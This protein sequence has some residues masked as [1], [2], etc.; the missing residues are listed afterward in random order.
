MKAW[1]DGLKPK[2]KPPAVPG[3]TPYWL[4][5]L[6]EAR[7]KDMHAAQSVITHAA[8]T[9]AVERALHTWGYGAYLVVDG[10]YGTSTDEAVKWFQAKVSPGAKPDGIL[11]EKEWARL[12]GGPDGKDLFVPELGDY[13]KWI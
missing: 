8:T 6:L 7:K 3:L 1:A 11:G 4:S 5:Y 2:P 10:H 9:N 13:K 12:A